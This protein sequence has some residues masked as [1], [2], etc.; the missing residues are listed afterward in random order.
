MDVSEEEQDD[1]VSN[2]GTR[3]QGDPS[4]S[5]P[6]RSP[7]DRPNKRQKREATRQQRRQDRALYQQV[8]TWAK[9]W[10]GCGV[11]WLCTAHTCLDVAFR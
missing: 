1:D 10:H 7:G 3:D 9:H 8:W 4:S 2:M 6:M 5:S 11:R